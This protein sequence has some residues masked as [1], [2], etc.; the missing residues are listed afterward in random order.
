MAQRV[1]ALVVLAADL[2]SVPGTTG[3][4]TTVAA[5]VPAHQV[6]PLA[7]V[8]TRHIPR[9]HTHICKTT[10]IRMHAKMNT[11]SKLW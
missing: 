7:S 8:G 10:H 2:G 5:A 9:E 3:W 6:P 11:S 1:R 4:L